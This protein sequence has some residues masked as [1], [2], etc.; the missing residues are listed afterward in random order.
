[1]SKGYNEGS[2]IVAAAIENKRVKLMGVASQGYCPKSKM[3]FGKCY[4]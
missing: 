3:S 1:M 2:R 4:I